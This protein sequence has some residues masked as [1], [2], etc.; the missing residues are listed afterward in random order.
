M[1]VGGLLFLIFI[2]LPILGFLL[3]TLVMLV[4]FPFFAI[5]AGARSVKENREDKRL[6]I[7]QEGDKRTATIRESRRQQAI[8]IELKK[9]EDAE[10]AQPK[11]ASE[12]LNWPSLREGAPRAGW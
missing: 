3:R 7:I 9:L 10:R 6:A 1:T 5:G 2:G 11:P 12:R 8:A 4:V